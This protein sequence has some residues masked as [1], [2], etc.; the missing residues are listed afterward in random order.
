MQTGPGNVIEPDEL[1]P[2]CIDV[3]AKRVM[4]PCL[5]GA[6]VQRRQPP[7]RRDHAEDAQR[8]LHGEELRSERG[9]YVTDKRLL[10]A[11]IRADLRVVQRLPGQCG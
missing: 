9:R 10:A 7:R 5:L 1:D 11:Y 8:R 6:H 3:M 2:T 4:Q